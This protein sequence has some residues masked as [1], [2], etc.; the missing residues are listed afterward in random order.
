MEFVEGALMADFIHLLKSDP[1]RLTAW[2]NENNV[3][4]RRVARRLSL[5][6]HRQILEDNLYHGDLHPGNIIL[7]RDSRIALIDC[8]T[9]GFVELE[10]LEKF[11]LFVQSLVNL[12]FDKAADMAFLLSASLPIRNLE[13][14]KEDLIRALRAWGA[15]T[16]VEQLPYSEKSVTNAWQECN[17]VY[18][19]YQ[20]TFGWEILRIFRAITTLDASLMHLYPEQNP[21]V[22]GR[23]YLRQ[24][25][26][27]ALM[28]FQT[29]KSLRQI[30]T[31]LAIATELPG[32]A[33]ELAFYYTGLARKQAKVFEGATTKVANL[34]TVLFGNLALGCLL[35]GIAIALVL[36]DRHAPDLAAPIMK[37]IVHRAVRG[38]PA[39]ESD[40]WL[41]LLAFGAYLGWTFLKLRRRFDRKEVNT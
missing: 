16:F 28:K 6:L 5:S 29:R 33:S 13:R 25:Q 34:F 18:V 3:D 9:V 30:L 14:A 20:C 10:Y 19:R 41:L 38:A 12:D 32:K 36:L 37:G 2:L 31:N 23:Q 39:F 22:S 24:S 15:R 35:G 4:Q 21:T 40:T 1:A 26:R 17:K 8:G 7:L 11:R 27:R